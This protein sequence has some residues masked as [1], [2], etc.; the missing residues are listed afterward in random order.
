MRL[1]SMVPQDIRNRIYIPGFIAYNDLPPYYS[2]SDIGVWPGNIGVAIIDGL[3][4][5]LPLVVRS[6]QETRHLLT[7]ENGLTFTRNDCD[8]LT[9]KITALIQNHANM[10][11][12]GHRSR[13]LA[14]EIFD[15]GKVAQ[16]SINIY[17]QVLSGHPPSLTPLWENLN[18]SAKES[19]VLSE[20]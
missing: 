19:Q 4:R 14:E 17:Q 5:G 11:E 1:L 12:M 15:W 9:A 16:R 18:E 10:Q 8:D 20:E 3:S 13:Q 6:S 2:A 7:R